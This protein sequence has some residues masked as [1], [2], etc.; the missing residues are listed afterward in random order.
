MVLR[1]QVISEVIIN[2][3]LDRDGIYVASDSLDVQSVELEIRDRIAKEAPRDFSKLLEEVAHHHSIQVMEDELQ[4]FIDRIPIGG[5]VVDV[6]AG[7]G[8]HWRGLG[9]YRPDVI[10]I[11]VDFS[12]ESLLRA[13][14]VLSG[15]NPESFVY[16]CGDAQR[17]HI[18]DESVDGYWSVQTLQHVPDFE[19]AVHEAKRILRPGGQ[20]ASYS[21]SNQPVLR[22]MAKILKRPYVTDGF[23]SEGIW[24]RRASEFQRECIDSIFGSR[25][26]ERYSEVLFT[27]E[28]H[29]SRPGAAGSLWGRLDRKLTGH[30]LF[31]RLFARQ[32]SYHI[33]KVA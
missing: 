30:S 31:A 8:W 13:M 32:C 28:L 29:L 1:Q 3:T 23:F 7:W 33:A 27:P 4:K 12:H 22:T 15:E 6:G 18:A 11:L 21:L 9:K 14:E 10:V 17:L 26:E 19:L 2:M 25:L 20:F 5:V 16:V 24:L